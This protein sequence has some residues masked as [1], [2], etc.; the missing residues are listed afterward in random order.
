MRGP[1][2]LAEPPALGY[3]VRVITIDPDVVGQLTAC[4]AT[5]EL[6]PSPATPAGPGAAQPP[7]PCPW[8]PRAPGHGIHPL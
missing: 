7:P 1:R 3:G 6:A 4:D 5:L 8:R 2:H